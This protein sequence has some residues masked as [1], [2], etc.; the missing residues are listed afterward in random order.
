MAELMADA[1]EL[2]NSKAGL[3]RG[4]IDSWEVKTSVL[5]AHGSG[6]R[7]WRC[8]HEH[9]TARAAYS[10]ARSE[11]RARTPDHMNRSE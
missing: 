2:R 5:G 1:V 7:V 11:L 10:C 3:W 8:A 9:R 4:V 6:E